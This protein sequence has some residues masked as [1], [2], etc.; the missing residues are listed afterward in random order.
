MIE[1][2]QRVLCLLAAMAFS[3][4]AMAVNVVTNGSFEAGLAGWTSAPAAVNTG[5]T[6]GF[7][8]AAP[9]PGTETV[10]ATPG[11]PATAGTANAIGSIDGTTAG[12]NNCV[13]YQD[14]FIPVGAT[15]ANLTADVGVKMFGGAAQCCQGAAMGL[16]STASVHSDIAP[17]A[18]GAATYRNP[19]ASDATL[20]PISQNSIN[21]SAL[22][23]TTVRL[24]LMIV[25]TNTTGFAVGGF[26]NVVLDVTVPVVATPSVASIP[27]LSEWGVIV[28]AALMALFGIGYTRRS[29]R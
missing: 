20:A 14:V 7:N 25:S 19:A 26:D 18:A 22:A 23:G 16:F 17:K 28:L 11:F 4:P 12:R 5:A 9:A 15:T 3:S 21:V 29:Q 24:Q 8:S 2:K 13:L 27:T 6:C 1:F 10:T